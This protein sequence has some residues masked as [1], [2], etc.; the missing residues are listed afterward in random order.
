MNTLLCYQSE[1]Q[2]KQLYLSEMN[3]NMKLEQEKPIS[4]FHGF[5]LSTRSSCI[6]PQCLWFRSCVMSFYD[7]FRWVALC[8]KL[9]GVFPVQNILS[10]NPFAIRY[11]VF[12]IDILYS[13]ILH[14]TIMG[15]HY[16]WNGFQFSADNRFKQLIQVLILFMYVRT[17]ACF[18]FCL[19]RQAPKSLRVLRLLEVFERHRETTLNLR[20]PTTLSKCLLLGIPGFINLLLSATYAFESGHLVC[21]IYSKS[22]RDQ[23]WPALAFGFSCLWHIIPPLFYVYLSTKILFNFHDINR[24]LIAKGY[25]ATYC[26]GFE[27]FD[28]DS[29]YLGNLR[30]F[31]NL[32]SEATHALSICYGSFI[33]VQ[34]L[35]LIVAVVVNISAYIAAARDPHLL[36]LTSIDIFH[37]LMMTGISHSIKKRGCK[38]ARLFQGIPL[39]ALSESSKNEIELWLLQLS[40]HPVHVN[41][42]GYFILDKTQTFEVLS[43]IATYLI[44]AV[45]ILEDQK[46][47]DTNL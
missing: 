47:S 13:I 12:S 8:G 24:A 33:S 28:D 15:I 19:F 32:L 42:A 10:R 21:E 45:Q 25:Y 5:S 39:S 2:R 3:E 35:F 31:H 38:V 44:V 22:P 1:E 29:E 7:S 20:T 9:L 11:R 14:T 27:K 6:R 26:R 43:S 16:W 40:V 34:K 30:V 46:S 18:V 41:A 4:R 37:F 17:V 36:V 23:Y